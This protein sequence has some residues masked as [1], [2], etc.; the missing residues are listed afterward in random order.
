MSTAG[1][2]SACKVTGKS[3]WP[4]L[5]G[6]NV[7]KAVSVI[8]TENPSVHVKVLNMSKPIPLPVDCARVI[9]FIDDTNKVALP[10][11]IC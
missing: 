5:M 1:C 9:V 2:S 4:E 8:Q 3:S 10:P 11:V 7:A 6:T